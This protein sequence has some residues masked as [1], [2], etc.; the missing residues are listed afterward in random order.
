MWENKDL[1]TPE[2]TNESARNAEEVNKLRQGSYFNNLSCF[3]SVCLHVHIHADTCSFL[4]DSAKFLQ[5]SQ[6]S[7]SVFI[8]IYIFNLHAYFKR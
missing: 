8:Y 2:K 1:W 4:K 5:R 6:K 7:L 3:L